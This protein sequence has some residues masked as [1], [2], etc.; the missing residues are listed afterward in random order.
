MLPP[1]VISLNARISAEII[2]AEARPVLTLSP[3]T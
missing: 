1:N 3:L 2:P